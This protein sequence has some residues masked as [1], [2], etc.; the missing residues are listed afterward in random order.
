M[1][2]KENREAGKSNAFFRLLE[3]RERP[4]ADDRAPGDMQAG[5]AV[6]PGGFVP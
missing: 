5:E 1:E 6:H 2:G 3:P 4:R